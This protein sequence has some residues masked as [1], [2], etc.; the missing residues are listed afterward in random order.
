MIDTIILDIGQVLVDF[1]WKEYLEE[2][3]YDEET[4]RRVSEA[5]VLGA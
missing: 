2:C 5:T 4:K 1:R 3:G